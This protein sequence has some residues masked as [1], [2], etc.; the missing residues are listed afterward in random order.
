MAGDRRIS[1]VNYF[2]HR[3]V[4][5]HAVIFLGE[6]CKVRRVCLQVL[7]TG[8]LPFPSMPW[9]AAQLD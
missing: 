8:P 7:P 4:R 6:T 1:P 2:V 3:I 5:K 9:Q